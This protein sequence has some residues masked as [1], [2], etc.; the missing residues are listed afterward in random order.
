MASDFPRLRRIAASSRSGRLDHVVALGL[1]ESGQA[2]PVAAGAFHREGH[3][4]LTEAARPGQQFG[5]AG[6]RGGHPDR[7][8]C[9]VADR[10]TRLVDRG[11]DVDVGVGVDADPH[12]SGGTGCGRSGSLPQQAGDR[13]GHSP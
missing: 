1:Q 10:A 13:I 6:R 2:G 5:V 9:S 11:G 4:G 12:L 8:G 7:G 3:D